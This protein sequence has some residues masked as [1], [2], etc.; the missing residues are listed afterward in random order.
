MAVLGR[1]LVSSAERLDLPDLLSIESYSAG[2]WQYFIKGLV[3]DSKPFILKGFEVIDPNSVI[4]TRNCSIRVAD[5]VVFYPGSKAGSF[6]HGLPEG[7]SLSAPLVP[8]LRKSATNYVYLTFTTANTSID[9]R[10]FWDPD[11]DGGAGGEF[12]QDV[13]T[14]SVL[15][16][17][18]N[19]S[20]GS[21]PT[22][23]IPVAIITMDDQSITS[24]QDARD[25]MFR[26]GSGGLNPNAFNRYTWRSSPSND[27]QR[28]ETPSLMKDSSDPNPF[29]GAD[30]NIYSLKEWMDA[31]MSK[32]QELGGTAYWYDD[33]TSYNLIS[34]FID[35]VSTTVKSKGRWTHDANTAGLLSWTDDITLKITSDSRDYVIQGPGSQ[36]LDNE[37]V[38]YVALERNLPINDTDED[39]QWYSGQSYINTVGGALGLFS[40]LS[41]GD[42]IKKINDSNDT[43]VR[44]EE[45]YENINLSG[46]ATTAANARSIRLSSAY[47]GTSGIQK[48]RYDR[49]YYNIGDVQKSDRNAAI[50]SQYGSNF[51]WLA[52]RSDNV[53]E[54]NSIVTTQLQFDISDGDGV[55]AKATCGSIHGLIDGDR[56]QISGSTNYDGIY[57]VE[58]ESS[59]IF[60][61]NTS[62][63]IDETNVFGCYATITTKSRS[64]DYG[65]QLESNK[66][67]LKTNDLVHIDGTINYNGSFQV[68]VRDEV[69]Y[70]VAVADNFA[71]EILGT[72]SF[73]NILVKLNGATTDLIQGGIVNI[74]AN[75]SENILTY[76]GMK[77]LSQN[78]P[79]YEIP[80]GSNTLYGTANY[81]SSI[82]EDLT[83][84]IARLTSMM[85]DK[86]QDKT[87]KFAGSGYISISN[88]LNT[89]NIDI[90]FNPQLNGSPRLDVVMS[91]SDNVINNYVDLSDPISLQHYQAA[92]IC[93]DRNEGFA[94]AEIT[95]SDIK[96]VPLDE[97]VFV[98]A[99]RL[100]TNDV[101]LW[102]AL[103]LPENKTISVD[104]YRD[105]SIQQNVNLKLVR[106]G[107]W[108]WNLSSTTLSNNLAAHIQ[109]PGLSDSNNTIDAQYILLPNDGDAAYV[110]INREQLLSAPSLTVQVENINNIIVNDD[111]FIIARRINNSVYIDN[112]LLLA[113][114]SKSLDIDNGPIKV[115]AIDLQSTSVPFSNDI[116]GVIVNDG[117]RVLLT[118]LNNIYSISNGGSTW[119]LLESFNG[120]STPQ[121]GAIVEVQDY[122]GFSPLWVYNGYNWRP[123]DVASITQEPTGF[124]NRTTSTLSFDDSS[125]TFSISPVG[126]G[127]FDIYQRGVPYR[128]SSTK[129]IAI[130]NVEGLHYIYFNNGTLYSTQ[131][132]DIGL[133]KTFTFVATVQWD[134]SNSKHIMLGDER[135]GLVM[136]GDTHAYLHTAI[137]ARYI[138]GLSA[139]NFTLGGDG[140]L[141][142]QAQISIS[143]GTINDEDI[144]INITHSATPTQ[145]FQQVLSPI[146]KIPVYYRDGAAGNW[147]KVNSN[148]FPVKAGTS[149]IQFNTYSGSTWSTIDATSD[150]KFIAMWVFAT[151]NQEEPIVAIMGQLESASLADAQAN[152][153]YQSISF[154]NLPSLE[155][156]VLYRLI[157]ETSS[158]YTNSIKASL[159]DVTDLR[160]AVD[161][162]LGTYAPGDHGLLT[163]LQDQDHPDYAIYVNNPSAYVGA[164]KQINVNDNDDVEKA[165]QSL[166]KFF[167]QMRMTPHPSNPKR[168]KISNSNQ[169]LTNG[170]TLT[171][172]LKNLMMSFDGAEIDF[173]TGSIYKSDGVTS[174][175][176]NFTPVSVPANQFQWYSIGAK[177]VSPANANNT[178]SIRL[179][180]TPGTSSGLTA[181]SAPRAKYKG[182]M[183]IGQ[184]YVQQS[185]SDIANITAAN[186]YQLG[187]GSGSGGGDVINDV[188]LANNQLV[189]ADITDFE[190]DALDS[191][192][193]KATYSIVRRTTLSEYITEGDIVGIYRPSTGLW[194]LNGNT[195][196]GDDPEVT[197]SIATVGTVGK[198]QYISSN[199]V[200]TQ[201]ESIIKFKITPL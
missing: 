143:N 53:Q 177:T 106:G 4:G 139:D 120:S 145:G 114:D 36:L 52:L 133:I 97:N 109:I 200:G 49:G 174:L 21:F 2:D 195:F 57:V 28:K 152:N 68:S 27:Y 166:D 185:G 107:I 46:N 108:S 165:L 116:D 37:Q 29:Q 173:S 140:S 164:L 23:T 92:Y 201:L 118:K 168:I 76:I 146:A 62:V 24:I 119:T 43:F 115:K 121:I 169:V 3:G 196:V 48:A 30:K 83:A 160:R 153:L 86:S 102:D 44:V 162:S 19:V 117:E 64:T 159:A 56:I 123:T 124:L 128:F 89:P 151:N 193:F 191:K 85:A 1:L 41:K 137:G 104:W 47:A 80:D 38:L 61:I 5:S 91:S 149:R 147:R 181:D 178:V 65:L 96:K 78:S 17:N 10:A 154:G 98:I 81:G 187:V 94:N 35:A 13:N 183:P 141:D 135:H 189:A 157:Y 163:G 158:T 11:K 20:T 132:F 110:E 39:V 77:S 126:G 66:H 67:G 184:V 194:S 34:N 18:V 54:I 188:E 16:V 8:E 172:T 70:T 112:M 33:M 103:L 171:Q 60:Y 32:L 42:Y 197:L 150:N 74:N 155:M 170:I 84:R 82:D 59:T 72:S 40:N 122:T 50:I 113:G 75:V 100:G 101:W 176:I 127:W 192:V 26:L 111:L 190:V 198:V 71:T 144:T 31:V 131:T 51:H 130:S 69:S 105:Q 45:F 73:T 6:F 79:I 186:I 182:A 129:S 175:G 88:S 87:I 148:N 93:V 14:E 7:N 125:R 55:T 138:S 136:D 199:L 22:N 25:M 95:V 90:T 63:S 99:V 58:V 161:V 156:K 12:T 9:T 179:I 142:S 167:A 180:V 15:T 134:T